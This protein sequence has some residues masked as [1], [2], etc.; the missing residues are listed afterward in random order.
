MEQLRQEFHRQEIM[1]TFC[2]RNVNQALDI[3]E[4]KVLAL[5]DLQEK[6]LRENQEPKVASDK[7]SVERMKHSI[8]DGEI[9]DALIFESG[10]MQ[11]YL[12]RGKE[13]LG[14]NSEKK[15]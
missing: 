11:G 12:Q 5:L 14:V 6:Q 13:V 2:A 7:A 15:E 8:Y 4:E 9:H 1:D 10:F 3:S